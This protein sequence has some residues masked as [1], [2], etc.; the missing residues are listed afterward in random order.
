[1]NFYK[2]DD[3]RQTSPNR[4]ADIIVSVDFIYGHNRDIICKGGG[5]YAFWDKDK[6]NT[7]EYD[8]M[9]LIDDNIRSRVQE[10]KNQY[11]EANIIGSYMS[12]NKSKVMKDFK[13]YAKLSPQSEVQFNTKIIFIII[14]NYQKISRKNK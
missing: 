11:P 8:L 14:L 10:L 1:M 12:H 6:W 4:K 13:E 5:M 2:I 9:Q 7:N 3:V